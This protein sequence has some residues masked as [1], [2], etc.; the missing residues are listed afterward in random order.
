MDSRGSGN[1]EGNPPIRLTRQEDQNMHKKWTMK[2]QGFDRWRRK[3]S[4]WQVYEGSV[5]YRNQAESWVRSW[6]SK[7]IAKPI[8]EMELR[9]RIFLVGKGNGDRIMAKFAS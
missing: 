7:V 6:G 5:R 4:E 1:G 9:V 2:L 8:G 3:Q